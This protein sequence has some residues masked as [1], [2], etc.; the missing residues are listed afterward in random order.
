VAGFESLNDVVLNQLLVTFGSDEET[1]QVIAVVQYD[2]TCWCGG[3]TWKGRQAMR[4]SISSWATTA[5]DI[6]R[7]VVAIQRATRQVLGVPNEK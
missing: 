2:G 4:I 5:E 3:T 6:D 1:D 7:S